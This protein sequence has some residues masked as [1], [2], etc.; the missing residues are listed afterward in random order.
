MDEKES[1]ILLLHSSPTPNY[2]FFFQL[3]LNKI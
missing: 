1:E 2:Y 3:D